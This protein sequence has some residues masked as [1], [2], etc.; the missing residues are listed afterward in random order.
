MRQRNYKAGDDV[1][2]K[3]NFAGGRS[4][5]GLSR[6]VGIL[7]VSDCGETQYKVRFDGENFDRRILGSD[8]E[9][10]IPAPS[11]NRNTPAGDTWLKP[12]KI[13]VRK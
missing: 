1:K 13:K 12:S 10:K 11:G 6:I 3:A 8:I 5:P 2:L 9:G 4:P 7:P